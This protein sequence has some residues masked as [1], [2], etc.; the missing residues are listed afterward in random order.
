MPGFYPQNR[1]KTRKYLIYYIVQWEI[2]NLSFVVP[3]KIS[4]SASGGEEAE[5]KSPVELFCPGAAEL[6]PGAGNA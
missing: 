5:R 1:R 2:V 6:Y 4:G 3:R